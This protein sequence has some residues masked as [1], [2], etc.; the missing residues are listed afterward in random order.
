MLAA[1]LSGQ[2]SA[3]IAATYKIPEG[4]VRAMRSRMK[5]GPETVATVTTDK[6]QQIGTLLVDYLHANLTT[7]RKQ[8][9][10]FSDP[11][12]LMK[13][14]ASDAAVLHGVMTDKAIRLLEALGGAGNREG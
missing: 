3:E 8:L 7:L 9:D 11:V 6:K 5:N 14:S 10:V 1:L 13:Q 2:G 12:W 4:T